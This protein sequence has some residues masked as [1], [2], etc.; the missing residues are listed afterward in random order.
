MTITLEHAARLLDTPPPPAVPGQL[1]VEGTPTA[2]AVPDGLAAAFAA[3]TRVV[4][5]GH[6]EWTTRS[7]TASGG[8]RFRHRGVD[9][10]AAQAAF[11]LRTGRAPVGTVQTTCDR[12]RCCAPAHVDDQ[13]TR[14]RDRAALAAVTGIRHRPPTCDHDQAIHG[15]HRSDGRRYCDACNNP[16]AGCGHGNPRCAAEPVHPYPCGPRCD[17]HQPSKTHPYHV[18]TA[19]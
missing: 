5:G 2:P 1:A 14:Q 17:E 4:E 19:Q 13:V 11:I 10:T 9:Y 16:K 6:R 12:P 15:R 8:G 3:R 18:A 7:R